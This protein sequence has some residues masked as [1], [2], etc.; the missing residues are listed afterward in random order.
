MDTFFIITGIAFLFFLTVKTLYKVV[1]YVKKARSLGILKVYMERSV[2]L[3][4]I[5][6]ICLTIFFCIT[7]VQKSPKQMRSW[8]YGQEFRI[9]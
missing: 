4:S 9:C 3:I 2:I 6:G 7:F 8:E 5:G 1:K